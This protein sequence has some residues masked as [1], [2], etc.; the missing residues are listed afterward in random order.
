VSTA[1]SMP[2]RLRRLGGKAWLLPAGAVVFVIVFLLPVVHAPFFSD[3][4]TYSQVV[5]Y[6]KLSGKSFFGLDAEQTWNFVAH[7]GRPQIFSGYPGYPVFN[8]LGEHPAWYHAY[9]L[10][11]TALAGAVVFGLLRR[12]GAPAAGAAL[13]VVLAAAW[14]QLR[15]Y[16]DSMISFAGLMQVIVAL[17]AGSLWCF[18][19]WLDEGRRRDL[20]LAVVL[21]FIACGTYEIAYA[22]C[23]AHIALAFAQRRGRVALRAAAPFVGVALLFALATVALRQVADSVATGYSVGGGGPWTVLRTYAVQLISPLPLTRLMADPTVGA[24]PDRGELFASIW[25]GLAVTGAVALLGLSLA[26]RPVRWAP[27]AAVGAAFYVA[28]PVLLSLAGKYQ[29]ELDASQAYLPVFMQVFGLAILATAA[30]GALLRLAAGRSRAMVVGVIA[31]AA[32]FAGL[33]GGVTAFNNIRVVGILQPDRAARALVEAA[34]GH[35]VFDTLPARSSVFF[36]GND[37]VWEGPT[38]FHDYLYAELMLAERTGRAYDAR[39][40]PTPGPGF[41]LGSCARLANPILQQPTCAPPAKRAAW[42]R[43]R[44]RP[45]GGTVIEAQLANPSPTGFLSSKTTSTLIAYRQAHSGEPGP[46]HL[47]G[48]TADGAQWFS[49]GLRWR[50]LRGRGTWAVYSLD[51]GSSPRPVASSLDDDRGFVDFLVMPSWPMRARLMNTKHLL[52]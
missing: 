12:L 27:I 42:A 16:H 13:A 10:V 41:V 11:L 26:R 48:R 5:G 18:A 19:R 17:V 30:F 22:L 40:L 4:I 7:S 32:L 49:D 47:A 33:A 21:F 37:M 35:G 50:R 24:D 6:R 1:R 9:L 29:V 3:D 20:V 45:D 43:V 52:P 44:L 36:W 39:V 2:V 46:P 23:L 15:I 34:A 8:L 25:R 51:L 31:A 28:P 38:T 14:M